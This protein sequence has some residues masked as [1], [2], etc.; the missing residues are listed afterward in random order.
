MMMVEIVSMLIDPFGITNFQGGG[1][2]KTG[3]SAISK[4]AL[5]VGQKR[6]QH[7]WNECNKACITNQVRN[8]FRCT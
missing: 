6:Y 8:M 4:S 5:Q 7:P 1:S 2:D 3:S